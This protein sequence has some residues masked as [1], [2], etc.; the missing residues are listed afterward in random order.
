VK[1]RVKDRQSILYTLLGV[2]V[3]ALIIFCIVDAHGIKDQLNDWKLLPE[4]EK[5]TELYF[6]HPNSL[7]STYIA[8]STQAVAFTVHNLEYQTE[9]YQYQIV[10][11]SDNGQQSQVLETAN[12]TLKQGQ[13]KNVTNLVS[14]NDLG[15]RVKVAVDLSN[16]NES[17]SYWLNGVS[18]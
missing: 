3:V 8:G 9:N 11:T 7:P 14:L 6:T 13:Y 15:S 12:F 5:L 16:V 2:V 1:A 10:E 18:S 17:I 4:P